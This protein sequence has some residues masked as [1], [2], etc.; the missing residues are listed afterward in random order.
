MSVARP[1]GWLATRWSVYSIPCIPL[2]YHDGTMVYHDGITR[3][4]HEPYQR[5]LLLLQCMKTMIVF[6]F[7]ACNPDRFVIDRYNCK[8][9]NVRL[10]KCKYLCSHVS[11]THLAA[12]LLVSKWKSACWT[13]AKAFS[14]TN[15]RA[16]LLKVSIFKY[17]Q[18]LKAG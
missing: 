12:V 10:K 11:Q 5:L 3:M 14:C 4:Y 2:L 1:V 6:S 8:Y 7:A 16:N 15:V 13:A 17:F 18:L 9:N